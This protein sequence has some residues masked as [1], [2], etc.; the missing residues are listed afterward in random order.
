MFF[1]LTDEQRAFSAAVRGYLARPVRPGRGPR[2]RRGPRPAT[3]TRPTLWKAA[4]RAGLARRHSCP[5][6]ST[7][8]GS[9][10]S[11][12]QVIARALGAGVGAGAVARHRARRRGDPARRLGRAAGDLAA[13]ARRRRGGA[14]ALAG[15]ASPRR[16]AAAL[17]RPSST[18]AI[19]DV[20]VVAPG[21][22]CL[23]DR[24]RRRHAAR[25]ATTAPC[26]SADARPAAPA[27]SSTGAARGRGRSWSTGPRCS[28]PP[29]WS[30]S[31]ARRSPDTVDVRQDAQAVRRAGRLVP[32]DQARARRPARARSR[33]PSTP[34]STPRTPSTPTRPTTPRSRSPSPR[35][36]RATPRGDATGAMIQ[37]HGGI[38]YTW[39]HDAHLFYKRAKR[40]AGP[41]GRRRAPTAPASRELTIGRVQ[42][43]PSCTRSA[44]RM[45]P[46][47]ACPPVPS[48]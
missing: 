37:Y 18:A 20:L 43:R 5:R 15:A 42:V 24:A 36:R 25:L 16:P 31:P 29:T 40:L 32:G 3:A 9:A 27:R 7:G 19:A 30:A 4:R 41:V 39:E 14:V 12:P 38:G 44:G 2:G 28:S 10:C 48:P 11:R 26:G 6:S 17:A 35:P 21:R 22:A 47:G 8:S 23:V 33:W 13:P 34:R 45:A 1:A 46:L